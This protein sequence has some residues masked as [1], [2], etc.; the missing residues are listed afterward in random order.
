MKKPVVGHSAVVVFN[1]FCPQR[2]VKEE[3]EMV[4]FVSLF[5]GGSAVI[6]L[7]IVVLMRCFLLVVT[8]ENMSMAPT[9]KSGDRVLMIRHWPTRWLRKGQIVLIEPGLG[10]NVGPTLLAVMPYIKRIVALGGETVTISNT[11]IT[12]HTYSFNHKINHEQ[13]QQVWHIPAG[14]LFVSGR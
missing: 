4:S 10:T 2:L 12:A 14:Y 8:V 6:A 11:D 1:T 7:I 13:R 5:I 9:L 3:M